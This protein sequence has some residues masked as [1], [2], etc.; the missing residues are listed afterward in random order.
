MF[1]GQIEREFFYGEIWTMWHKSKLPAHLQFL[2]EQ[3]QQEQVK[4]DIWELENQDIGN[5]SICS[6]S[7]SNS[8]HSTKT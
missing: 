3:E 6:S 2:V 1:F 5:K 8:H 4:R 7:G